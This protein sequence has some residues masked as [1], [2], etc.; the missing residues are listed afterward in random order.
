MR[1]GYQNLQPPKLSEEFPNKYLTFERGY[2]YSE[3]NK[4]KKTLEQS[5]GK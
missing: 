1:S 5:Q 3:K 4:L 2:F